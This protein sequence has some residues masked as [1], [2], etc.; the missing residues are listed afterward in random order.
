MRETFMSSYREVAVAGGLYAST[1]D[2][3]AA[4]PLLELFELE[5]ALAELRH[6]LDHRPDCVGV[7]LAG[8]AALAGVTG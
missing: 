5:R 3:D 4:R 2:F 6:E 1:A 7:P 8:I